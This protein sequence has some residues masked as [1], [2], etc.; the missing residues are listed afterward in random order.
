MTTKW[1]PFLG[2][3][4]PLLGLL[5]ACG[6]GASPRPKPLL[7]RISPAQSQ[8][9]FTNELRE[10]P[11]QNVL[12][13]EYFYNGAGVAVADF[14]GDDSPDIYLLSNLATNR[15]FLQRA[16]LTFRD[17]TDISQSG[18]T[19]GFSTGVCIVDIN[20]DGR[21]DLYLC[22]SGR[23]TNP[24]LRRNEL[25]INEGN[26]ADG[27]PIF[28]EQ[29]QAYGLDIPAYSTQAAFFDYDRDGDL[30]LFLINH[31]ID[32]YAAEEIPQRQRSSSPLMGEM[33]FANEEGFFREV[34]TEA[35]IVN[36]RLGFG[37]GLGISDLNDDG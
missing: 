11:Q 2:R 3:W 36:N 23:F 5:S 26:N 24:E 33:L 6:Q 7:E 37:L 21:L 25:L 17:V 20:A 13:Y 29:A 8:L 1:Y 27:I 35:G 4:L 30:D 14:N 31:G 22:K 10:S 16:D 12:T 32:T 15:L 18:G 19:R 9:H 28:S 34:T